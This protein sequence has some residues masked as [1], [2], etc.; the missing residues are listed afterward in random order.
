M[1]LSIPSFNDHEGQQVYSEKT[2][3]FN[4]SSSSQG[5][6][7]DITEPIKLSYPSNSPER[8]LFP[9]TSN[10]LDRAIPFPFPLLPKTAIVL[11]E[12]S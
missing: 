1:P 2:C 3:L 12:I 5:K 4:M 8:Q 11:H 10:N 9:S 6:K 7:A